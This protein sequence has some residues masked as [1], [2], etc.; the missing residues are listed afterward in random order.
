M[1]YLC[2]ILQSSFLQKWH[3]SLVH[4]SLMSL[5][6]KLEFSGW[7]LLCI[8]GD[9]LVFCKMIFKSFVDF[10][11]F[12][13]INNYLRA[14]FE[15]QCNLPSPWKPDVRYTDVVLLDVIKM[16]FVKQ[17]RYSM[18]G[19]MKSLYFIFATKLKDSYPQCDNNIFALL[20][21]IYLRQRRWKCVCAC[22]CDCA[23]WKSKIL[24]VF[25][26]VDFVT[27]EFFFFFASMLVCL[28]VQTFVCLFVAVFLWL[29]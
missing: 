28:F 15:M 14:F 18:N 29:G 11:F 26:L 23:L 9:I 12:Q 10:F 3:L 27:C 1:F 4:L 8:L 6:D 16:P 2:K 17:K 20:R 24:Q 25:W 19:E 5:I 13:K 21:H 7:L 22:L